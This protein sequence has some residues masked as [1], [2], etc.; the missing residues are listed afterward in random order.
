LSVFDAQSVNAEDILPHFREGS[1]VTTKDI[2]FV[3]SF[4]LDVVKTPGDASLPKLLQENHFEIRPGANM[5]RNQ[6][7]A[8]LKALEK[9]AGD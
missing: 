7:K 6:F 5:T 4:G 3:K 9:A 1:L 2:E 8:A